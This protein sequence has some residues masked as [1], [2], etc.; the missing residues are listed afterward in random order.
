MGWVWGCDG[1]KVMAM[2]KARAR[3]RAW[4][5]ARGINWDVVE[6]RDGCQHQH[7]IQRQCGCAV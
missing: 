1:A 6:V 4:V 7:W 2:L 5:M 3:A